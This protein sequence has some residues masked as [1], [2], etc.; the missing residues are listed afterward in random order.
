MKSAVLKLESDTQEAEPIINV[1]KIKYLISKVDERSETDSIDTEIR[2][3]KLERV[4]E[5]T[6][7]NSSNNK[8]SDTSRDV[9]R[10]KVLGAWKFHELKKHVWNQ[11][12]IYEFQVMSVVF[13]WS[14]GL[15][16]TR[17]TQN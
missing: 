3:E 8:V 2:C 5:F 9:Y 13:L 1:K 12:S 11:R 10:H 6:Y 15:A 7:L 16:R 17:T 14:L 4:D